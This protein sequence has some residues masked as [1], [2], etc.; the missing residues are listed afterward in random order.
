MG[1]R[2]RRSSG[3]DS[4]NFHG[5]FHRRGFSFFSKISF[6]LPFSPLLIIHDKSLKPVFLQLY[7]KHAPKT[8]RNFIELSRRGYYDNVKFHR[9]IKVFSP[10]CL[11]CAVFLGVHRK[12]DF[13]ERVLKG[14]G[15]RGLRLRCRWEISVFFFGFRLLGWLV[16]NHFL[17]KMRLSD[18]PK[19]IF[20]FNPSLLVHLMEKLCLDILG[21][22]WPIFLLSIYFLGIH[23]KL[24][25]RENEYWE[26]EDRRVYGTYVDG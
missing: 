24:G 2:R 21:I 23:G 6:F 1:K 26:G 19:W 5:A 25:F 12:G 3:G 20:T 15:V 14:W 8:C 9:I 22:Y 10:I 17:L 13:V 4:G 18:D 11:L 16:G 7:N